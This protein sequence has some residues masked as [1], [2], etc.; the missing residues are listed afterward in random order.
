MWGSISLL[1]WKAG[2]GFPINLFIVLGLI[3][4]IVLIPGV[5]F[6]PSIKRI[7]LMFSFIGV[8]LFLTY[9]NLTEAELG[10]SIFLSEEAMLTPFFFSEH[11]YSRFAA[12][13]FTLAGAFTL[14]YGAQLS[15]A[16]EQALSLLA[17]ASVIGVSFA[18][19]FITL[20]L[21]WEVLTFS[22]AGIIF[23][24]GTSHAMSMGL[25]FLFFHLVG[26]LLVLLGILQ[27]YAA[28]GSFIIEE[29]QAGLTFF[30]LGVG[31]KAAFLPFHLW[32]AWGYPSASFPSSVLL[33]GLTT[34]IGIYALARI[35][36]PHEFIVLM[37]G[38]MALIG[39]ICA[40][41]QHD[42][43]RLLSYHIISQVG[44]MVAGVGLGASLAV[45]GGLLHMINNMFYKGLLFMC[46]GAVIHATGTEN[47]HDLIHHEEEEERHNEYKHSRQKEQEVKPL[48]K[49]LPVATF[50]AIIGAFAIAGMPLFSGYVSKYMLKQAMY[51]AGPAEWMLL[52][53]G[54]GTTASFCKF[55][56]FGFIKARAPVSHKP[57][58][59]M[60]I[61]IFA[62]SAISILIGVYPQV[63]SAILPYNSPL[64]VYSASGVWETMQLIIV[65]VLVFLNLASV[66]KKGIH[67]PAWMSIENLIFI[68]LANKTYEYLSRMKIPE[69]GDFYSPSF[70]KGKFTKTI[71]FF[72]QGSYTDPKEQ[73]ASAAET[74]KDAYSTNWSIRNIGFDQL[75]M[76]SL[77]GMV[78]FA[79]LYFAWTRGMF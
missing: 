7:L 44:Y 1:T 11:P 24:R 34:K 57:T 20:F 77:L 25:R 29:P 59:T 75:L 14:L 64:S 70:N 54:I 48:W 9:Y 38:A 15:K 5:L 21:F 62:V 19:N 10:I 18:G 8:L 49:A 55:V 33:A 67:V 27:H 50:G 17:L 12:F 56:Y 35:I 72:K 28:V 22:T 4:P 40:L 66:L 6:F 47:V 51:G 71:P 13:G 41:L 2:E 26:G 58:V 42:L 23:C 46:A 60:N 73:A 32:V 31:F 69:G 16:S 76:I 30:V 63:I 37:G 53:A 39:V 43:R 79:F 74:S 36:P 52:I 61:S 65:G 3:V 68:P 45:D 78:I